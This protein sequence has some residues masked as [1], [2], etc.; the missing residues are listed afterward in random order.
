MSDAASLEFL[1]AVIAAADPV[2]FDG[3]EPSTGAPAAPIDSLLAI[4]R[5][6][7]R[8][9][10]TS[11]ARP[12]GDAI[13][14]VLALG[15]VLKQLGR[16][17]H[18]ALA[19]PAP[20]IYSSL[21]GIEH[22]RFGPSIDRH[23]LDGD[24]PAPAILL[25]C[26]GIERSGLRGLEA[27]LLINIDHHISGRNFGGV[28]WIDP[29]ASAVAVMVY[30]IAVA[31]NVEITPSMAT[32]I[33]TALLS[34]TGAF[35]YPA[36]NAESFAVAH[37]LTLCGANPS[38]IA[39]D[40]YFSSPLSKVRLLGKALDGLQISDRI[41]WSWVTLD[42]LAQT[43][44]TPEDCE[45]IVGNLIGIEGIDVAFLLRE[46]VDGQIRL[47]I[48]SKGAVNVAL[49]AESFGGGGHVNAS[50]CTLPGPVS[51]AVERILDAL[52]SSYSTAQL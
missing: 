25:E 34:D 28:N 11:H 13:G 16:G 4:F 47:S 46:Q 3:T 29:G 37:H 6:H 41:A 45:G 7:R 49:A 35:T 50:G 26:D 14:S 17:T 5:Q 52:R 33:Y 2:K 10:V 20:A 18:L 32:C 36:T 12:D 27:R 1:P 42:D 51:T 38:Q 40:L 24:D 15:E 31:A 39:R 48:R 8:F 19:D 23:S 44:A 43:G 22:I 30:R 21:P 9:I